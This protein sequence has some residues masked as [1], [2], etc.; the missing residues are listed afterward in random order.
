M[1][2]VL[3]LSGLVP[4]DV[5]VVVSPLTELVALL[6]A[7]VEP[8]HHPEARGLLKDISATLDPQTAAEIAALAPLWARFRCRVFFPLEPTSA[9]L[10]QQIWAIEAMPLLQ[11]V[12]LVAE[13]IHGYAR[14]LPM[15]QALL[16]DTAAQRQ[17]TDLCRARSLSRL[18][19]AESLVSDPGAFRRRLVQFLGR[20]NDLFFQAEWGRVQ[21]EIQRALV[22]TDVGLRTKGVA[23]VLS[24]LSETAVSRPHFE[25]V[26]FDKLQQRSVIL[27]GRK[28]VLVPSVRQAP[29]LTIKDSPGLPVIVHFPAGSSAAEPFSIE[30]VR[31]RLAALASE[32]RMELLR[33]LCAEPITTSELAIRLGQNPAQVSRSLGVLRDAGLL[34]SQRSGKLVYHRVR[35]D[36][37][38]N[39]GTDI[40]A[41]LVR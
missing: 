2:I 15:P 11:F 9:S 31:R 30:E 20:A 37:V 3:K 17:F 25:E 32:T 1:A 7:L 38:L 13:G 24:G 34:V 5:H 23:E 8:D 14:P 12:E 29:H 28:L 36:T 27:A 16:E 33:H 35:M 26:R 40:L 4:D 19:L 6:H 21:R 22:R 18:E 39:L 41:T 10:H